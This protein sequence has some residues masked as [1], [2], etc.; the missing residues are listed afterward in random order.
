MPSPKTRVLSTRLNRWSKKL[1]HEMLTAPA[2]YYDV[3]D[4]DFDDQIPRPQNETVLRYLREAT[5]GSRTVMDYVE[6]E[7]RYALNIAGVARNY[8]GIREDA[9][10]SVNTLT[11]SSKDDFLR[12]L[13]VVTSDLFLDYW[14]TIGDGFH[15]TRSNIMSFP[16]NEH[17]LEGIDANLPSAAKM[18]KA[19][20][21]Y[22]KSKLNSGVATESFDFSVVSQ[23]LYPSLEE[24]IC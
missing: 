7:G 18:W 1:R 5:R 8:I 14:L 21:R 4:H 24:V 6:R 20:R 11:F 2:H 17:L 13:S 12:I 9:G 22:A 10:S 15:I 3:T 16:I 23:S 19:R